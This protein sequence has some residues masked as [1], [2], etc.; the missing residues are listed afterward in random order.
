MSELNKLTFFKKIISYGPLIFLFTSVLNEIDFNYINL[1][2][3]SFNFVYIL[4][5]FWTLKNPKSLNYGAIF[6][7]GLIND[8]VINTPIGLSSFNY[9]I[10][11]GVTA[12]LRN[13]T[14]RPSFIRDW[15]FFLIVVL[16]VNSITFFIIDMIFSSKLLYINYLINSVTTFIFYPLFSF[17]FVNFKKLVNMKSND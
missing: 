10:I 7:A 16:I 2:Y 17:M 1:K 4:I 3:F 14:I 12:Y 9:L 15:I 6:I 5:F 13:I 8:V 11:C